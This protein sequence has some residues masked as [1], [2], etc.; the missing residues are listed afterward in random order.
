MGFL[1]V[2]K[3]AGECGG[4]TPR[5]WKEAGCREKGKENPAA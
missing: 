4:F 5:R 2:G 3:G 1:L